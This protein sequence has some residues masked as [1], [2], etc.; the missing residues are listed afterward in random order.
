MAP[1]PDAVPQSAVSPEDMARAGVWRLL[2]RLLNAPPDAALLADLAGLRGDDTP[3]GRA[4][5]ALAARAA[6]ISPEAADD[7]YHD[8][9]IGITRGELVPFGSYYLTGFLNEKPLARL[10]ADMARL[11]F[12]RA[13]TADPEDHVASLCDMHAAIILGESEAADPL[14]EAARFYRTH[15]D[16]WIDVFFADLEGAERADLYAPVGALGLA[17]VEVERAALAMQGG[18]DGMQPATFGA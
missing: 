1:R 5:S 7:E 18:R 8:L 10:R 6:T 4:L 14:A 2:G 15:L 3:L 17:L 11:G 9:F 12:V 16:P 13:G